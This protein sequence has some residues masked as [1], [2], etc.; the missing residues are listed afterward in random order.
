MESF[1]V[2]GEWWLPDR[3]DNKANGVLR[4]KPREG[5]TLELNGILN[6]ESSEFIE[7]ELIHGRTIE[8]KK[9]TLQRCHQ[10]RSTGT[11]IESNMKTSTFKV[12]RIFKQ[13]YHEEM[14]FDRV[15]VEFPYLDTWMNKRTVRK[16]PLQD[17]ERYKI[18]TENLSYTT[19]YQNLEI[20][21]NAGTKQ[22]GEGREF[23]IKRSCWIEIEPEEQMDYD[24]FDN[25]ISYLQ[26]FL[27]LTTGENVSPNRIVCVT[28][29][30]MRVGEVD[31]IPSRTNVYRRV[32]QDFKGE[33]SKAVQLMLMPFETFEEN[34]S[35]VL[36]SWLDMRQEE[37]MKW[38]LNLYFDIRYNDSMYI[39]QKLLNL[40]QGL[41]VYYDFNNEGKY[42]PKDDFKEQV[43]GDLYDQI[44]E[45]IDDQIQDTPESVMS[46]KNRLKSAISHC[47]KYSLTDKLMECYKSHEDIY[48]NL[49]IDEELVR[50]AK[51]TRDHYTHFSLHEDQ[52][53][54]FQ[55]MPEAIV[56]FRAM[57]ELNILLEL[58]LDEEM[59]TDRIVNYYLQH[60]GLGK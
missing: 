22:G 58:G 56:K 43:G 34:I 6:E 39:N 11:A 33:E 55:E 13:G 37:K 40:I 15:V 12:E 27:N 17:G 48:N 46:L 3:E 38:A 20:S 60:Y 5:G 19:K 51:K 14:K 4:F 36:T 25:Y 23:H 54:S 30:G 21:F 41:E 47:Y 44:P 31:Y 24:E 42:L 57:M 1:K 32:N 8:N 52:I 16:F 45:D 10:V 59:V 26:D 50:K 29:E 53:L 35:E 2:R 18:E 49:D 7:P 9:I 28:S